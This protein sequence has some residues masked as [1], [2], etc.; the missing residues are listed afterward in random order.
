MTTN[1]EPMS[2]RMIKERVKISEC[3][4][5][6]LEMIEDVKTMITISNTLSTQVR[7]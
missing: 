2:K 5:R 1:R 4:E 7:T 6:F 3:T